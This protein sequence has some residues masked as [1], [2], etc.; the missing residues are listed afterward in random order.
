[1]NKKTNV[2]G[3]G[4]DIIAVSRFVKSLT[5]HGGNF[6]DK[7]FTKQEQ[8][9]CN[10]YSDSAARFAA[11]FSAK[12]A[13]AKSLGNGFNEKLSF[14]DIEITNNSLGKPEVIL[15]DKGKINF[16]NPTFEL[17]LSHCKEY[18]TATAIAFY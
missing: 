15:S 13:V 9:Y 8:E 12:E 7:I 2:L 5:K 11:R 14:L 1:M 17:S 16:N 18:A 10:K 4:T 6:L 3:I